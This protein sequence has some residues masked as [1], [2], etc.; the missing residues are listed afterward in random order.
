MAQDARQAGVWHSRLCVLVA[1][2]LVL[3]VVDAHAQ[4]AERPIWKVGNLWAYH[5]VGGL[6]PAESRWSREV[7][8]SR[9]DGNFS[10]RTETGRALVFD[11]ETNSLDRRGPEYSWKRFSFP[12][13]VGKRWTHSRKLA[14][15][16]TDGTERA[17]WE[18]KAFEKLTVPA[19]TFDCFRVEGVVWQS[20]TPAIYGPWTS[21]EDATY[22]YCPDV[23][24]V[25]KWKSH[26]AASPGSPYI[27]SESVLTSFSAAD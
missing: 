19:G 8:E 20:W 26:R 22:W 23:K 15:G 5:A 9:A 3:V 12:L 17:T 24:W 1:A 2:P 25:A 14:S 27:D 10:V 21:H 6:P 11:G 7:T 13:S 16:S 18:V 4:S